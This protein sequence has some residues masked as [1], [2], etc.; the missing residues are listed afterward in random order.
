MCTWNLLRARSKIVVFNCQ[1]L[2]LIFDRALSSISR[3]ECSHLPRHQAGAND[4]FH[5]VDPVKYV[6]FTLAEKGGTLSILTCRATG[7][8]MIWETILLPVRH[9]SP[10]RSATLSGI[11]IVLFFGRP[12]SL[13]VAQMNPLVWAGISDHGGSLSAPDQRHFR[14]AFYLRNPLS[15]FSPCRE[16][17][18]FENSQNV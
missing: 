4:P 2:E 3:S 11:R 10:Q 6:I 16:P 1:F 13:P 12:D 5:P 9:P 7:L 14:F 17:L 18:L 15:V 8:L